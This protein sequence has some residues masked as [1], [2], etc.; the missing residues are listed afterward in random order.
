MTL[1]TK[2]EISGLSTT[3]K[4]LGN[5][6]WSVTVSTSRVTVSSQMNMERFPGNKLGNSHHDYYFQSVNA[7]SFKLAYW[8]NYYPVTATVSVTLVFCSWCLQQCRSERKLVEATV[9]QGNITVPAD[10]GDD[11]MWEKKWN[12]NTPPTPVLTSDPLHGTVL[13][14]TREIWSRMPLDISEHETVS[15]HQTKLS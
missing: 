3:F 14:S 12:E 8:H 7:A 6:A 5:S 11:E 4:S 9:R 10:D 13:P 2:I 1:K 15:F